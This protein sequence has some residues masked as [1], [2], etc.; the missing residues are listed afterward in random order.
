MPPQ[1]ANSQTSAPLPLFRPE[2]IAA[3][4][5]MEGEVVLIRPL[6]ITLLSGLALLLAFA[7]TAALLLI[8]VPEIRSIPVAIST[9]AD[10]K[11]SF[12]V[13]QRLASRLAIG[14]H[15]SLL[16]PSA[17]GEPHKTDMTILDLRSS[18][19]ATADSASSTAL[20]IA[21]APDSQQSLSGGRGSAEV[22]VGSRS[23]LNWLLHREGE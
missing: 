8:R 7:G 14:D 2:P 11:I 1:N 22:P 4:L 5:R 23:L 3:R 19:A 9:A 20:V 13:P 21:T 12:T 10:S 17:T 16:V 18:P 6:S 15:L